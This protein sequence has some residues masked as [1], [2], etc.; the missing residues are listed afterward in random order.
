M[1]YNVKI[2]GKEY[3]V[4]VER[5]AGYYKSVARQPL[6]QVTPV[7]ESKTASVE[8]YAASQP[9]AKAAEPEKKAAPKK[10]TDAAPKA[11]PVAAGDKDV[12]SPMPGSVWDVKVSAGDTVKNGQTVL[13]LE[14]MKMEIE[15]AAT[16]DGVVDQVL[17]AKGD[18]VETGKVLVTLK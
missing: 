1:K 5:A 13:I 2:N 9:A 15:V 18:T 4:E 7:A 11:A 12:L 10:K 6:G 17:V 3:E 16:A 14:A 8:G